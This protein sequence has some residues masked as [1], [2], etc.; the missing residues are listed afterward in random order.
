VVFAAGLAVDEAKVDVVRQWPQPRIFMD[1]Q[2]F[3]N[4]AS[5]YKRFI[6]HFDSIMA[7]LTNCMQGDKFTWTDEAES[8]I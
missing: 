2:S 7:P 1:M 3:H 4:L 8:A 5:S 6:P